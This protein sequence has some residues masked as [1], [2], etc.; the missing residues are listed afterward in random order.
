ML[1]QFI[2]TQLE[3]NPVFESILFRNNLFLM[4]YLL[5][6]ESVHIHFEVNLTNE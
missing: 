3:M 6:W 2:Y 4:Q 1:W 5:L